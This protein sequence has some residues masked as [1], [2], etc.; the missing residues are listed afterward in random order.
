MDRSSRYHAREFEKSLEA[1]KEGNQRRLDVASAR[2]KASEDVAASYKHLSEVQSMKI[3]EQAIAVKNVYEPLVLRLHLLEKLVL[4]RSLDEP[5]LVGYRL[6]EQSWAQHK[7]TGELVYELRQAGDA[8]L[9]GLEDIMYTDEFA[10]EERDWSVEKWIDG[11][12]IPHP[13][14]PDI[15]A[16]TSDSGSQGF[17][18]VSVRGRP[19]CKLED[20]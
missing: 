19:N 13:S 18:I 1:L 16:G 9:S 12:A 4:H 20:V 3:G 10:Q 6:P 5:P 11:V 2:L 14:A 15:D 7:V 8:R 17:E